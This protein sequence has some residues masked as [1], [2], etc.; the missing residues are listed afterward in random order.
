MQLNGSETAEGP[1]G[2]MEGWRAVLTVV[3][4]YGMAEKKRNEYSFLASREDDPGIEGHETERMDVDN[5]KAM[6]H[7][8]KTRGVGFVLL[9]Y[10]TIINENIF[11]QGKD[12]LKYVKGL[13]G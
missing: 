4:R 6:V 10:R 9:I 1:P 2:S 5:V 8:V 7:G 13:L 12:L 11:S 3:L